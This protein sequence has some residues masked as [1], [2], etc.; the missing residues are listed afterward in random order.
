ML[1]TKGEFL[2]FFCASASLDSPWALKIWN[3]HN[4]FANGSREDSIMRKI[5]S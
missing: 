5:T 1:I 3:Y 4:S 2:D